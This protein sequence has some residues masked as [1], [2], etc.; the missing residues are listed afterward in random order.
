M[1]LMGLVMSAF[2]LVYVWRSKRQR[3]KD[4]AAQGGQA[5]AAT[6]EKEIEVFIRDAETRLAQSERRQGS[7]ARAA[8]G[9]FPDRRNGSAAKTSIFVHSG[10]E[11]DLLAGQVYQDNA[12]ISTRPV[13]FWLAQ[14]S[15]FVEA[16]GNLLGDARPLDHADQTL[17][18][19]RR[20]P[21]RRG[22]QS[23]RA[24]IVFLDG[25]SFLKPNAED[26]LALTARNLRTRLG[27]ISQ[28]LGIRLPVYVLFTKLDRLAHFTDFVGNLTDEEVTQVLGVTLP[29]RSDREQGG[30]YAEEESR[31]LTA[32]FDGLVSR[33]VRQTPAVSRARARS[34][35]TFRR[36]TNFRANSASCA[37]R[38]VRFLVDLGRPSQLRANPFLRGFYFSGVRPGGGR[39]ECAAAS[40]PRPR[41][42]T[43]RA[44]HR[45]FRLALAAPRHRRSFGRAGRHARRRVPQWL[46][47]GHLFNNVVLRDRAAMGASGQSIRT[48]LMRRILAVSA[49]GLCLSLVRA[50]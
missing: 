50:A 42:D 45:I 1:L 22:R 17:N 20:Y 38:A 8:A 9:F 12:I 35:Q 5:D 6:A 30:V 29:L 33:A 3:A 36:S 23:P 15:V 2:G 31:R 11:P 19:K 4:A 21:F 43:K 34:R 37:T 14:K 27:E 26:A 40:A 49:A 16:G 44:R 28:A 24:A 48:E 41:R 13:N 47:L 10:V 18:P 7:Q 46:F 32:A 25:E 39:D